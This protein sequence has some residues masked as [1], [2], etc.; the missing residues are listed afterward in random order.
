MNKILII[1]GREF[2][3][4]VRKKTFLLVTIFVPILVAG[5]YAFMLWM[6]L[7][8]DTQERKIAVVN[9]SELIHPLKRINNNTFEYGHED[10]AEADLSRFLVNSDYYAAIYVPQNIIR[11][12]KITIYSRSQIPM[13]L[14]NNITIQLKNEIEKIKRD[15]IIKQTGIPDLEQQLEA[16]QT[17]VSATTLK[18]DEKGEARES[19]S[20]I[21][22]VIGIAAGIVI[23]IFIFMYATQVMQGVL[24]E[25]IN[26][27]IEV[28]VS[29][30][31]PIQFLFGKIIGIAGVGL[32]QFVIW[33]VLGGVIIVA[34]QSLFLSDIDMESLRNATDL[35]AMTQTSGLTAENL[36]TIRS[37]TQTLTPQFVCSFLISFILYFIGGYLLYAA[38]FAA[39]GAAVDSQ[40]ETQ[41]FL[42]PL[43]VV[44]VIGLYIG[45]AAIKSPESPL[46]FWTSMIPF[47]SPIVMLVRIPFGVATW[48]ILLS[49][50]IL[51]GTF[52][53][54][55]WISAKIYRIGILM[56]GKK[57][58]WKEI[59]KWLKY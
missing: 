49:L 15:S 54:I 28:L 34:G 3:T 10:M 23:Y 53:L 50:G 51:G 4:R 26:R 33:I 52:I 27:I 46:V 29:S 17:T 39:I 11:E 35:N 57:A 24:E 38:M 45:F 36:A 37:I 9:R 55:T 8:D 1:I 14:E 44:L 43:S 16:T 41:Q 42:G 21:T 31:K 58:S 47:T 12:P 25:K 56:Y 19:S 22:S 6:M 48:E 2:S 13:E 32:L 59:Y 7:R 40:E 18:I 30:V 5:L 20:V